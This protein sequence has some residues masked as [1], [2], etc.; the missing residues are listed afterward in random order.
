VFTIVDIRPLR[1]AFESAV[2][3]RKDA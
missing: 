1:H 2:V 3:L